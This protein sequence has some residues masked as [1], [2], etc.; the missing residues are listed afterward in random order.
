MTARTCGEHRIDRFMVV[1][2]GMIERKNKWRDAAVHKVVARM[3]ASFSATEAHWV[4]LGRERTQL[5]LAF[6]WS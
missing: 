6:V 2:G 4:A 5:D 3:L 1:S